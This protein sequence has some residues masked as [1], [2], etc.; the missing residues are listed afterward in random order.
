MCMYHKPTLTPGPCF[1]TTGSLL[2]AQRSRWSLFLKRPTPRKQ[3]HVHQRLPSSVFTEPRCFMFSPC[4]RLPATTLKARQCEP[5]TLPV[6]IR[7]SLS[8]LKKEGGK[9]HTHTHTHTSQPQTHVKHATAA[10]VS[11]DSGCGDNGDRGLCCFFEICVL[12]T[13]KY[14]CPQA[15]WA[16]TLKS[17]VLPPLSVPLLSS[18]SISNSPVA[19]VI[20]ASSVAVKGRGQR[21]G[22]A[23]GGRV[24]APSIM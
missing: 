18:K 1:Q 21:G 19:P 11:G 5:T 14:T 8:M 13:S 4:R 9:K 12:Y 3:R 15:E 22:G 20:A 16:V 17:A 24:G 7:F 23:C 2:G 6:F 10:I